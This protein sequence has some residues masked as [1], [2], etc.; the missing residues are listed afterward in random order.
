MHLPTKVGK[1]CSLCQPGAFPSPLYPVPSWAYS[2][3]KAVLS[4]TAMTIAACMHRPPVAAE[5]QKSMEFRPCLMPRAVRHKHGSEDA[6]G[7]LDAS[8]LLVCGALLC[9]AVPCCAVLGGALL[10]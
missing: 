9:L 10:K 2:M 8:E 1:H 5:R 6:K 4:T 7:A 3:Q